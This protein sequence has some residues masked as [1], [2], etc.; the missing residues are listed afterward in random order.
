MFVS[1]HKS[2]SRQNSWVWVRTERVI[3]ESHRLTNK[4]KISGAHTIHWALWG[5]REVECDPAD[6]VR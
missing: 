3:A 6:G 5:H 2:H 4:C 1:S